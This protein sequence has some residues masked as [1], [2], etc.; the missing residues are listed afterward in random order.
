M[1]TNKYDMSVIVTAHNEGRLAHRTMRSLFRA[2]NYANNNGVSTEIVVVMDRPA[3]ET[4]KCISMYDESGIRKELVDIGDPGLSRNYGVNL[5]EGRYIAL[6]DADDLIGVDWL[7]KAFRYLEDS[8]K[9]IIVHPE[10]YVAFEGKNLIWRPVASIDKN[11]HVGD[12]LEFNHW[13]IVCAAGR[14]ILLRHPFESTLPMSGYGYEDWHFYCETLASG[15]QHHMVPETVFFK[16]IKKTGSRLAYDNEMNR[17][18]GPTKL[19]EPSRFS[20]FMQRETK[21]GDTPLQIPKLTKT[22]ILKHH[23]R[24]YARISMR[25]LN[26]ISPKAHRLLARTLKHI[27][28]QPELKHDLPDWLISEW[29][30]IHATEPQVYPEQ[31]VIHTLSFYS[32]PR[33]RLGGYYLKLCQ[34]FGD[35]VSHVFLVPWIK[36]GGADLETLNYIDA[37]VKYNLGKD[38]VVISTTNTDSP[39][40]TRLPASTRLIEFGKLCS[41]L[42]AEEQEKLLTRLLLQMASKVIHNINSDLGYRIFVKYGR[43]LRSI[44]NLYVN[45]FCKDVT[46]EG[47]TAGYP[48]RYLPDCFDFLTAVASDNQSFLDYLHETYA[49]DRQKM[50]VHYQPMQNSK[51]V[52]RENITPK[53]TL[54][55]LWAGRIDRQKR[56]DILVGIAEACKDIPF[57]FHVYGDS[58]LDIDVYTR[59]LKKLKNVTY[60]GPFDGLHSIPAE[61]YDLYLYTSQ[62]DGLPNV[63]LEAISLGLPIIASN[64]GGVGELIIPDK[65]GYLIEPFDDVDAYVKTLQRI[66]NNRSQLNSVINN[67]YNLILSRHSWENFVEDLRKFPDYVTNQ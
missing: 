21:D 15:V 32:V 33:S 26:D 12:L 48:F 45:T 23:S 9:G 47:K 55:I 22:S 52:Q 10:Y 49:L 3:P 37:L 31:Q 7:Y 36:R 67:A 30:A 54:D 58:L 59:K 6:L 64:V 51:R 44:S 66:Y 56:P 16:R 25:L 60:Y 4:M 40:A 28:V 62:W 27:K 35:K 11:F 5:S 29:K 13:D 14:E 38:V 42:S 24:A 50:F 41:S 19:F 61:L 57:K 65:T 39:W 17:V 34:L 53:T 43:A 18:I 63:L 8:H 1:Q 20:E 46:E 2:I